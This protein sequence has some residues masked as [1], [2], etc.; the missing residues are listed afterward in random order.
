MHDWLFRYEIK[1][2]QAYIVATGRMLEITGGSAVIEQLGELVEATSEELCGEHFEL[3][4]Q[5][6]GAA[7]LRFT[8]RAALE[9]FAR[10]WPLLVE[11]HAPG[12]RVVQA[13][14]EDS[15]SGDAFQRLAAELRVA[16]N[17]LTVSLPEA[18]PLLARAARTG[19]PAVGRDHAKGGLLDAATQVRAMTGRAARDQDRLG[20]RLAPDDGPGFVTDLDDLGCS[21]LAVVHIDGNDIGRRV[22]SL[23]GGSSGYKRFSEALSASTLTASRAAVATLGGQDCLP[24]RP[25]VLG[26]DDFTII[27]RPGDAI[28]LVTAWLGAFEQATREREGPLQAPGGLTACAGVAFVK[29]GSPFWAAHE[30]AEELCAHA[31]RNLRAPRDGAPTASGLA[32]HRVTDS[33]LASWQHVAETSLAAWRDEQVRPLALSAGPYALHPAHGAPSIAALGELVAVLRGSGIPAGPLREWL[34]LAA[35]NATRAELHWRRMQQ[36]VCSTEGGRQDW[37]RLERALDALGEGDSQGWLRLR[38]R[39]HT[40]LLD[41]SVLSKMGTPPGDDAQQGGDA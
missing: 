13:W 2:I 7:T 28:P 22:M 10:W 18:G 23:D 31:K 32:F 39:Q 26:G 37:R 8:D 3:L 11:R 19:L 30:L 17:R 6:A 16:G 25:V 29:R 34:H 20:R 41:A 14:V 24:A 15:T 9:T 33:A 40:P 1:G 38:G 27:T 21:Y 35:A 5:A 4:A 36:V 12:L